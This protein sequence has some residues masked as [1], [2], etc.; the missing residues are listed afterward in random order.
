MVGHATEVWPHPFNRPH[1]ETRRVWGWYLEVSHF[2]VLMEDYSEESLL[3]NSSFYEDKVQD[4][5]LSVQG[6][7]S[8]CGISVLICCIMQPKGMGWK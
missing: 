7:E 2:T 6:F 4:L 8:H 1:Q 3:V 5:G